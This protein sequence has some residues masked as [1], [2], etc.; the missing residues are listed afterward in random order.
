MMNSIPFDG[1]LF[2][3]VFYG[4]QQHTAERAVAQLLE[5]IVLVHIIFCFIF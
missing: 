4:R 2:A 3:R 1:H 5:H